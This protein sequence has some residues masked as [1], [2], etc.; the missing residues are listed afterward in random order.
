M[1]ILIV[2]NGFDLA[3]GLPTSYSNFLGFIK[4]FKYIH[5]AN[6][7]N[8]DRYKNAESFK[9]LDTKIQEYLSDDKR[10]RNKEDKL[11][12]ELYN[13]S[14]SNVWIKHL[15]ECSDKNQLKGKN[16]I[17]FESEIA[18]VVRA[19]E[20]SKKVNNE[21]L[22]CGN[23]ANAKLDDKVLFDKA[24]DFLCSMKDVCKNRGFEDE[25]FDIYNFYDFAVR[26]IINELNNDLNSLIRCLE[27]YLE[28]VVGNIEI[29]KKLPDICE[30]S[31]IDKLISFN[32]TDTFKK[33]YEGNK[34][35]EYDY[36]HGKLDISSSIEENNM[37]LGIDEYLAEDEKNKELD[38]IHFKKYFQRIYKKTGCQ[39]KNW[40]QE[41]KERDK[42]F[43]ASI[44]KSLGTEFINNIYIYGHSLDITDKDILKELV[45][46]SKTQ[47]TIFYYNKSDY[48]QKIANMVGL[49]GQDVLL[50]S[51]YGTNPSII[52]KQIQK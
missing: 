48:A 52:F 49:I 19:L 29:V 14:S 5:D 45:M 28:D 26:K 50:D 38:F 9:K 20:Y 15:E 36:I 1:N 8:I 3:H 2:G 10:I 7:E 35:V 4:Y 31:N 21:I 40:L 16:W 12:N 47:T 6:P 42:M 11:M 24:Y 27:I 25:E 22:K 34:K 41:M 44:S 37:V 33:V 30:I 46:F 23:I 39:Y 32:Y 43:G 17:D 13:L 51:V 18:E